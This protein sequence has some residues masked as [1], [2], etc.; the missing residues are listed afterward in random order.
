MMLHPTARL[1]SGGFIFTALLML[2]GCAALPP[3]SFSEQGFPRQFELSDTAF[4]PQL[5]YQCGPAALATILASAQVSV[6][7]EALVSEIYL[8]ERQG[9]LQAELIGAARRQDRVPYVLAPEITSVLR[10]VVAGHPVLVLQNLG[11]SWL[12]Q[13]HYAVVVGFD[14]DYQNLVLRSGTERRHVVSLYTFERTWARAQHW[15]MVVMPSNQVPATATERSFL[16]AVAT[17]EAQRRYTAAMHGYQA[18][19]QRWPE[20]VLARFGLANSAFGQ[21]DDARA[22]REYRALLA[23]LPGNAA[24]WNNLAHVLLRQRRCADAEAAAQQAVKLGGAT[25]SVARNTLAEIRARQC[26]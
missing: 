24:A 12:P 23:Q 11:L 10:E 13:W 8:S 1:C 14:L 18:A 9:T 21:Q 26:R 6:V 22:E 2:A 4:F 19:L 3:V 5:E 25:E 16:E 7:P 15:A 17:L 20:S